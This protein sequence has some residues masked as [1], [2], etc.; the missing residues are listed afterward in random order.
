MQNPSCIDYLFTNNAYA[1]QQTITVFT[2]LPDCH[3]LV[4]SVLKATVP[5]NYPKEITS[6]DYK[7]FDFLKF[8]DELH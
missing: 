6:R 8:K 4:S 5:R 7:Q 3:K 2:G 1:F